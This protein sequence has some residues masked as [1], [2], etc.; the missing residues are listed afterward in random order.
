MSRKRK[1]PASIIFSHIA[2]IVLVTVTTDF[3]ST[4]VTTPILSVTIAMGVMLGPHSDTSSLKTIVI[5]LT[6]IMMNF[7]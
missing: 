2:A 7:L 3:Y 1:E 4:T 5:S 6:P